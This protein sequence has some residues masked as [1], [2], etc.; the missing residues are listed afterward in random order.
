MNNTLKYKNFIASIQF[1]E[2]DDAFIGHIEGIESS[3]SFEGRSVDELKAAFREAVA[4]YLDFC[5]RKGIVPQ[6]KYLGSFNVR[7]DAHLYM[8][9]AIAARMM[10]TTLNGFIKKAVEDKLMLVAD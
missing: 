6:K 8:Q 3:V 9:T 2:E 5:K 1:S 10:G 4:S 7:F